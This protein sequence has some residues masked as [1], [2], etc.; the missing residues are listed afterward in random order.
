ME[1]QTATPENQK[2]SSKQVMLN[3]G[4]M[5]GF[6]SILMAVANF[7]FGNVYEPHWIVSVLGIAIS[8]VFIV[9]GLKKIKENNGGY[10][11]LGE[12]IKTGLGIALIS[13]IVYVIYLLIFTSYIEPEF[14][15]RT[16]EVQE[17]ALIEK[18]PNM[19][20]DQLQGAL[21]MQKKFA[22]P[23]M[24]S[25]ITLIVSLFFGFIVSLVGG[26]IMKKSD[27]AVDSI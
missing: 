24:F 18:Y 1:N 19:T 12:A 21:D 9:L 5:L 6:V 4:L 2:L 15:A 16:L 10:L 25:A 11:K 22:G 27:E 14:F 17:Q 3:Y 7:A 8:I 20:D 13:G 26:L 23:L